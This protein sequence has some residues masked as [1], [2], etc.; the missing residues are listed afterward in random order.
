MLKIKKRFIFLSSLF[1]LTSFLGLSQSFTPND[2]EE[3]FL[4]LWKTI[5]EDYAYFH[6]KQTDWNKVKEIYSSKLKTVK[7]K[8]DFISFLESVIAEL[9]DP[10]FYLTT[11]LPSS[12]QLA[13]TGIDM[14]VEWIDGKAIITEIK[15][16]SLAEKAGLRPGMEIIEVNHTSIG[17][18]V[19]TILP[20]SLTKQ[21][22]AAKN[23]ALRS[24]IGGDRISKRLIKIYYKNKTTIY[25]LDPVDT[26]NKNKATIEYGTINNS[27]GYIQFNNSLGNTKTIIEFDQALEALKNTK[28]LILDLR[29]TPSGGNTIV[30]KGIIGRLIDKELPYQ[31]SMYPEDPMD[32]LQLHIKDVEYDVIAPRGTFTYTQPIVVLVDHW[33][34]SM[35]EGIAIGMDGIKRATIVGTKMAELVGAIEHIDLPRTKIGVNYPYLQLYHLN[36][37]PRENFIPSVFIDLLNPLY[38]NQKNRDVI[39]EEGLKLLNSYL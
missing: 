21:D 4:F 5:K 25:T 11:N 2:F 28:G 16:N 3:D 15:K 18:L 34:A 19:S 36:G 35:G 27:I 33:T 38:K 1:V 23:W 14:W 10:H 17:D 9:Y 12:F 24:A 39:L 29:N 32:S 37:T 31:R 7:S 13:P 8:D 6:I 20:Q 30:A 26:K 22:S